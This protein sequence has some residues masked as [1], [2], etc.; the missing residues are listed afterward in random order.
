MPHFKSIKFLLGEEFK[1]I[2]FM[3]LLFLFSSL[4][5]LLGISLI[6]A[7]IAVIFEP[8]VL[9]RIPDY[10]FLAFLH[11]YSHSEFVI[12]IGLLLIGIFCIKFIFL[13]LTN[14]VIIS[15]AAY[16]QAKVQKL[17]VNGI[18]T[19]NYE[20]FL[21]SNTGD[22][23]SSI[24][25]FSGVYRE[26]LQAMLQILSNLIIIL[27]IGI[28]LGITSL[29]TLLV[30][31]AMMVAI[32]GLYNFVFSKRIFSYGKD[33]SDGMSGMIQGTTEISNGLKEIKTLGKEQFFLSWVSRSVD[34]VA[35]SALR[36]N[37]LGLIP[38]NLIE[39]ILITFVVFIVA[40]N[41]NNAATLGETLSMLGIFTAGMVRIAPLI[42]QM[43]ISWNTIIYGEEPILTLS[44]II[45]SQLTGIDKGDNAPKATRDDQDNQ[46]DRFRELILDNV[47]YRYPQAD[48]KSIDGI[49]FKIERGD[50]IGFVGPSGSGKTSLINIIL[51]FLAPNNGSILFNNQS[52][53]ANLA[54]WRKKCAY[55][56]QDIFLINGSFKENIVLDRGSVNN[57]L[58]SQALKLSKLEDFISTLPDGV[59][60]SLGDNGVRISGGQKQRVAIA[61]AIYHQREILLLDESTSALDSQTEK[62]VM[63]ELIGLR[64]EKTIIAIAH[65]ISTLK[66]CNKIY[67]LDGGILSG[68]F[69]YQEIVAQ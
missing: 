5:D 65:R 58:L 44:S 34:M 63:E 12:L 22:N 62:E 46:Q 18:I 3:S 48:S 37:F 32:F 35:K 36:L 60:T 33:Y 28:F 50:F 6:G 20:N 15:F 21:L 26:V 14:Y 55:L 57:E 10:E 56:P 42:S 1:K 29:G 66:E 68:P 54:L 16:E 43:Q 13:L 30:L 67:K 53:Q 19:Q 27:V 2:F 11:N 51:G 47:S 31:I 41:I 17:L 23:I 24:A 52:I 45:E 4:L 39:V 38:R 64:G 9:D 7:Y 49:S 69:V 59:E 25:N 61:R 40:A 8:N